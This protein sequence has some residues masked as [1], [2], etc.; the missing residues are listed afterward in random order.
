MSKFEEEFVETYGSTKKLRKITKELN[1]KDKFN[2]DMKQA[3]M[4]ITKITQNK[5]GK[6]I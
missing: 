2:K 4:N 5:L 3:D 6:T 1:C